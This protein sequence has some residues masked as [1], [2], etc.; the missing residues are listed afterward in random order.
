MNHKLGNVRDEIRFV[1][2]FMPVP[3]QESSEHK[4]KH[5]GD[6]EKSSELVP[7][8]LDQVEEVPVV[9]PESPC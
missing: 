2:R 5:M 8:L 4:I 7:L 9:L 6:A 3:N 1:T